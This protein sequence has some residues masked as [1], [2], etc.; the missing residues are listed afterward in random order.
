MATNTF[1]RDSGCRS[2]RLTFSILENCSPGQA[3]RAP[4]FTQ[5][6]WTN[7]GVRKGHSVRSAKSVSTSSP[8]QW[9]RVR[10]GQSWDSPDKRSSRLLSIGL[11][12]E[13]VTGDKVC[14][15]GRDVPGFR[16]VGDAMLGPCWTAG[17]RHSIS[18]AGRESGT[19]ERRVP[20]ARSLPK[21]MDRDFPIRRSARL[22][23]PRA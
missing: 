18:R 10:K 22:R 5:A 19:R 15:V 7:W 8:G 13:F 3:G 21:P 4:P 23:H 2:V 9:S 14:H 11:C 20:M 1:E 12:K 6:E 16:V 17:G